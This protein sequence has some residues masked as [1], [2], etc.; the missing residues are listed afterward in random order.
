MLVTH[1]RWDSTHSR[2]EKFPIISNYVGFWFRSAVFQFFFR[3][4]LRRN[5]KWSSLK[6]RKWKI[7]KTTRSIEDGEVERPICKFNDASI[8]I[9]FTRKVRIWLSIS[10]SFPPT[11]FISS[12]FPP[13]KLWIQMSIISGVWPGLCSAGCHLGLC[14]CIFNRWVQPTFRQSESLVL[15]GRFF[16]GWTSLVFPACLQLNSSQ[17]SPFQPDLTHDFVNLRRMV[18]RWGN[19]SWHLWL[20]ASLLLFF[21]QKIF[22]QAPFALSCLEICPQLVSVSLLLSSLASQFSLA[23]F[24]KINVFWSIFETSFDTALNWAM[25][26]VARVWISGGACSLFSSFSPPSP[27]LLP[28]LSKQTTMKTCFGS[29]WVRFLFRES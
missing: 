16:P 5:L 8:R 20:Q 28:S 15:L 29:H 14:C 21:I 25:I 18:H 4:T 2:E 19:S 11:T 26:A 17:I 22:P 24:L 1:G 9:S 27:L 10:L 23:G 13:F 6:R 7:M 3:R 12:D